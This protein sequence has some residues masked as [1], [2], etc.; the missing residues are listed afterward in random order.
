MSWRPRSALQI[1]LFAGIVAVVCGAIVSAVS[2]WLAPLQAENEKRDRQAVL[3]SMLACDPALATLLEAAID[4]DASL[5]AR[6]V[7]LDTGCYEQ[8]TDATCFDVEAAAA[9]P[10]QHLLLDPDQDIASI[11]K[12]PN[13]LVVYE[14]RR[15]GALALLVLPVYGLGYQSRLEGFLGLEADL[16]T[17]SSLVFYAHGET[18]GMG[19]RIGDP[20]WQSTWRGKRTRDQTGQLRIGVAM[21][22]SKEASLY[23]VDAMSG[24]TRTAQGVTNLLRFW[25]GDLGYAPL[26]QRLRSRIECPDPP[27]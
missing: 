4:G 2:V 6:V 20:D 12:R 17:V 26:V 11:R 21:R 27:D 23:E 3:Q 1:I 13:R 18:P 16:N 25:L 24:A 7:D 8:G 14:V 15:D 19:A 5:D 22:A 9:G 10:G